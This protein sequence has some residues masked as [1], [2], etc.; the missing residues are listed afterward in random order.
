MMGDK[1]ASGRLFLAAS[2]KKPFQH[3]S[4]KQKVMID[5]IRSSM[6]PGVKKTKNHMTEPSAT[7]PL[8]E[9]VRKVKVTTGKICKSSRYPTIHDSDVSKE[10]AVEQ[11]PAP[12]LKQ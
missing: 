8:Y 11:T 6:M 1:C 12:V 10:T 5:Q 2:I 7:R 3:Q 4:G 9:L